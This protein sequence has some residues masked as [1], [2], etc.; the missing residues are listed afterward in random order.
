MLYTQQTLESASSRRIR[1]RKKAHAAG[2]PNTNTHDTIATSRI[3]PHPSSA[4]Q[5]IVGAL[6]RKLIDDTASCRTTPDTNLGLST[7]IGMP[8]TTWLLPHLGPSTTWVPTP[9]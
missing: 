4:S 7:L 8:D 2:N 6:L 5:A 3:V 1:I 9:K